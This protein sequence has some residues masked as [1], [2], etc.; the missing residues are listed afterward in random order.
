MKRR[1]YLQAY[2]NKIIIISYK[3]LKNS[4]ICSEEQ[5]GKAGQDLGKE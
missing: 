5:Q 1:K 3:I 2:R 4:V